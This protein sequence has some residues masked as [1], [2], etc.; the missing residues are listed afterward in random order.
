MY[1]TK[2]PLAGRRFLLQRSCGQ[3]CLR[4]RPHAGRVPRVSVAP[5]RKRCW[6]S[7][8]QVHPP[9]IHICHERTHG[10]AGLSLCAGKDG[11]KLGCREQ[12]QRRTA[13]HHQ[14]RHKISPAHRSCLIRRLTRRGGWSSFHGSE[15]TGAGEA[16]TITQLTSYERTVFRFSTLPPPREYIWFSTTRSAQGDTSP[17]FYT[18][19]MRGKHPLMQNTRVLVRCGNSGMWTAGT[20]SR[21]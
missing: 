14:L 10:R 9:N 16:A 12:R 21:W 1:T 15:P 11:V 6:N 18:R 19:I 8:L 4:Q 2:K 7:Q 3:D 17:A 20:S 5:G 13:S